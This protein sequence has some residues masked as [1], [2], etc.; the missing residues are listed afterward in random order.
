MNCVEFLF[1]DRLRFFSYHPLVKWKNLVENPNVVI[2]REIVSFSDLFWGVEQRISFL[3][4]F[5]AGRKR[6]EE[7]LRRV[8]VE[9]ESSRKQLVAVKGK[10]MSQLVKRLNFLVA[11]QRQLLLAGKKSI[12]DYTVYAKDVR[13][14][15]DDLMDKI[16]NINIAVLT[17]LHRERVEV[18]GLIEKV[19]GLRHENTALLEQ[20]KVQAIKVLNAVKLEAQVIAKMMYE[21]YQF[22]LRNV[23]NPVVELKEFSLMR[24]SVKCR[25]VRQATIEIDNYEAMIQNQLS[26]AGLAQIPGLVQS[27]W[28]PQMLD[29]KLMV[30]NNI[31][32]LSHRVRR[33]IHALLKSE[34]LKRRYRRIL[35]SLVS[36]S[37]YLANSIKV[38]EY[39]AKVGAEKKIVQFNKREELKKK[40]A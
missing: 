34:G 23:Y 30:E 13:K 9:I 20:H 22:Q 4:R 8:F 35:K 36:Q 29:I 16:F 17:L 21:A 11:R 2:R 19:K 31:T 12:V 25:R 1:G 26:V 27:A 24:T 6:A 14:K 40:A 18:D 37:S 28:A 38:E 15:I 32:V 5:V 10:K 39:V 33:L 3:S 7:E